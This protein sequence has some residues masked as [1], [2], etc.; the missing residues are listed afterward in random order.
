[1]SLQIERVTTNEQLVDFVKF[2]WDVYRHDPL[3]APPLFAERLSFFDKRKNP[4]FEHAEADYF[5]ARRDGRVVGSIA[6]I[7]NHRHNEYRRENVAHFGFFEVMADPLAATLL[8]EVACNWARNHGLSRILG[9]MNFSTNDECGLLID[10]FDTPPVVMLTYNPP[11]YRHYLEATG[12]QK[13]MDLL[14]WERDIAALLAPGG[15]P[16]KLERVLTK[17]RQRC[18]L[19]IR[20][21]RLD[22]WDNEIARVKQIY[23]QAWQKNWGFVPMTDREIEHLARSLRPILD[24]NLVFLVE[25][26]GQPV[27]FSLTL[28]DVNELLVS[29]RPGPSYLS[30]LWTGARLITNKTRVKRARVVALG[31]IE[32]Y[33]GNGVDALL[34][35]TSIKA[36]GRRG[37]KWGEGSWILESNDAMNRPIQLLGSRLSKRFRIYSKELI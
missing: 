9:P 36:A 7:L 1:V 33:R 31:V 12:F 22:D 10:G 24:P 20:P 8:L 13:A 17:V 6:A 4:F 18:P 32:A 34:Y 30:S 23:N 28:P 35:Y 2:P 27:G 25:K 15:L 21:V 14:A 37:Y 19:V 26:E 29:L 3:W 11:Y 5:L 16:P